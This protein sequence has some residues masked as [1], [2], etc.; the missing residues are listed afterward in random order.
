MHNLYEIWVD[1]DVWMRENT[2]PDGLMYWEYCLCYV[3][4]VLVISHDPQKVI[5]G[6]SK[7]YTLKDDSVKEP[8]IYMGA[9][10]SKHMM[11]GS[12]NPTKTRWIN[13]L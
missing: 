2:K 9:R 10:I 13:E 8:D 4:G 12:D 11:S 7:R 5:G 6:L 1:A 3:D